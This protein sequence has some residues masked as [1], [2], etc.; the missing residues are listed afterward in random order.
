MAGSGAKGNKGCAKLS[1]CAEG[2]KLDCLFGPCPVD[3]AKVCHYCICFLIQKNDSCLATISCK[4]ACGWGNTPA[5]C[6]WNGEV[7]PTDY[8][9]WMSEFQS[10]AVRDV[11]VLGAHH[12]NAALMKVKPHIYR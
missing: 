9:S 11:L 5:Q 12:S 7:D 3:F 6:S 4:T 2:S 1:G 8:S 10:S